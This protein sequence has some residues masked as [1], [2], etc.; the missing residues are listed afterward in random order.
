M[1]GPQVFLLGSNVREAPRTLWKLECPFYRRESRGQRGL[2]WSH[3]ASAAEPSELIPVK[4][5]VPAWFPA[6]DMH[7]L[8]PLLLL[9][10]LCTRYRLESG[11]EGL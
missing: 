4:C 5:S 9:L 11:P 7:L 10:L 6:H 8:L 1:Q 3:G 2:C